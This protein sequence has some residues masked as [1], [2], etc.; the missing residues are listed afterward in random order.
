[1]TH[2]D[3]F[4]DLTATRYPAYGHALWEPSSGRL[5]SAVE[6]GD[7]GFVREGQ[8]RRLFNVLLPADHPSHGNYGV[9]ASFEPLATPRVAEH[10]DSLPLDPQDLCS[11]GVIRTPENEV[12]AA[13]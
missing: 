10:I 4:R 6:V 11:E 1:M 5:Y 9:P 12:F 2:Y 8:F 3:K 13:A 7:V